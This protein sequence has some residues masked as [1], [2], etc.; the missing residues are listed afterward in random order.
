MRTKSKT[1]DL[2]NREIAYNIISN[3][4]N[5][6]L[7]TFHHKELHDGLKEPTML[8]SLESLRKT[9]QNK[10]QNIQILFLTNEIVQL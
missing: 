6:T 8:E 9:F 10:N 4:V 7:L 3:E 2:D 5:V 1:I